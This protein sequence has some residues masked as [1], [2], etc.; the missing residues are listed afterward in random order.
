MLVE[1]EGTVAGMRRCVSSI[2]AGG[3]A[4]GLVPTMGALHEGHLSLVRAARQRGDEVVVSIFVNPAQFGPGEDFERYPRSLEAD[5]ELCRRN[6]V[7]V[8]FAPDVREMYPV[9]SLTRMHVAGLTEGLCGAH[10]PGHFDGVALVVG[11]LFNIVQPDRAY[12]GQKDA[13]QCAVIQK[14]ADDLNMQLEVVICPTVRQPDG[15]AMS[16]RN[17]YLSEA[18]R[19]AAPVIYRALSAAKQRYEAGERDA[20]ALRRLVRDLI[21][22]EPL[23]TSVD[24]VS[25]ADAGTLQELDRVDAPALLSLAVRLGRT[26]LIDNILLF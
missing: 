16:S 15:L 10:R 19:L 1:S 22:T 11:K 18:E 9:A 3:G 2:R 20:E 26:R 23:F 5:L 13:Q 4:V 12:F 8:V 6:D 7:F 25:V 21:A 17:T 24:Y 14:M